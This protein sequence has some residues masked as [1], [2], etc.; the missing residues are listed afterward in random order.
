M[1]NLPSSLS[2]QPT[3]SLLRPV[4]VLAVQEE[5]DERRLPKSLFNLS[6]SDRFD[7]SGQPR[8]LNDIEYVLDSPLD[9]FEPVIESFQVNSTTGELFLIKP[10]D[11]D[12]P[13]GKIE[14]SHN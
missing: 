4:Y 1:S 11:R 6:I 7:P 5:E 9:D 12:P 3:S 10:L 13:N 8:R 2:S 14:Y